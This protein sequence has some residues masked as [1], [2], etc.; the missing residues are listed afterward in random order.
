M[1][2]DRLIRERIARGW[3]Q[4]EVAGKL[5]ITT[6]FYGMIE[7]GTRNPRLPLAFELERL[8]G[9]PASALFPDLFCAQKHNGALGKN[10]KEA[11]ADA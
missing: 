3:T 8:F 11:S 6:S 4:A 1:K 9:L 7:Q 10:S 2:R 5:G